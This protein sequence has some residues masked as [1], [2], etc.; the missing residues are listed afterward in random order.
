MMKT[1]TTNNE[2][3]NKEAP[4]LTED[5][6][7]TAEQITD[8][9][10]NG[11]IL[12]RGVASTTELAKYAPAI[13]QAAAKYSTETRPLAERETYGKAFL[14]ISNL[15][16]RDEIVKQ[17]VLARRFARIAAQLMGVEGVRLYHDQALLKEPGGGLTPWHQDQYYW[18]LDTDKTITMWMPLEDIV[19]EMGPMTFASGSHT[20][21]YLGKLPI[22]DNSQV[23][24]QK[25]IE[26]RGFSLTKGGAMQAGDA[27]F[28]AGWVLHSA[29]D[30]ATEKVREAMT[31]IY[32]ADGTHISEV[33][34]ENQ[35]ADLK[36]WLP[37]QQPGEVASSLLNPFIL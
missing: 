22:S 27:T 14:Q 20:Q 31:I 4:D 19:P 1:G 36:K 26:E 6:A 18:P 35:A 34:N 11:H 7:L 10:H 3:T 32:F 21:G 8:F 13:R 33:A 9:Q 2:I 24:F 25:F 29:P 23:I 17:F 30:N 37:G 12:L 28:H 5:Y 15:W 16:Q